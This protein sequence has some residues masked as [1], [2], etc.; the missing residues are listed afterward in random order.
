MRK[1]IFALVACAALAGCKDKGGD[2]VGVWKSTDATPP[3]TLTVTKAGDGYRALNTLDADTNGYMK[4]EVAT[5]AES[6]SILT[7]ANKRKA[8][9]LSGDGKVTSYLRNG[10]VTF[11]KAQ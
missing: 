8:L 11:I 7:R 5:V 3:Q 9:E 2:F 4:V 6:D 10:A 1:L